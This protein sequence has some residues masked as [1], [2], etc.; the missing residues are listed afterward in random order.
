MRMHIIQHDDLVVP[1]TI[2]DWAEQE[3]IDYEVTKIHKGESLPAIDSFD[4]VIVLGGR[5]G[6]NDDA[7]YDWLLE[8]KAFLQHAVSANKY[9]LGICLGAQ[10]LAEVLGGRA[11][12]NTA[13]EIGWWPVSFTRETCGTLLEGLSGIMPLMQLHGDTVELPNKAENFA[14]S[15]ATVN[16]AFIVGDRVVGLQFHPEVDRV[17]LTPLA[18]AVSKEAGAGR[19][20]QQPT[21]YLAQD[22][23][24]ATSKQVMGQLLGNFRNRIF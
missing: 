9:V 22:S 24:F 3:Q 8:E 19:F 13:K 11:Y 6:A 16:Q 12:P 5:M 4:L 10:L 20:I 15:E 17:G 18:M 2:I 1:G 23:H 14:S 21:D 7:L